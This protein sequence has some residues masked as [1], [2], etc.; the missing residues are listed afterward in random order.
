MTSSRRS[1]IVTAPRVFALVAGVLGLVLVLVTPP[2]AG[3]D[4]TAHFL[5]A[6]QVAELRLVP[7]RST[8]DA[9]FDTFPQG[10][11][12]DLQ[13]TGHD[14][15]APGGDRTAYRH[16]IR[17]A[18]PGGP[19]TRVRIGAIAGYDPVPY[20]PAAIAIRIGRWF[21]ASTLEL[22]YLARFAGLSVYVLLAAL[23]VARCRRAQWL[24]AVL[25]LLPVAMF[26]AATVTI[27]GITYALALL[28]VA[29]A[30]RGWLDHERWRRRDTVVAV[31][32]SLALGAAKPPYVLLALTLV[33]ALRWRA[34]LSRIAINGGAAA[35]LAV[36]LVWAKVMEGPLST[37]DVAFGAI[38]SDDPFHPYRHVDANKQLT[39]HI[40]RD[41]FGFLG[42][43]GRTVRDG[44]VDWLRDGVAQLKIANV[45]PN[46]VAILAGLAI[47]VACA[48]SSIGAPGRRSRLA[49]AV[50]ALGTAIATLV[51][52]YVSWNA[53]GSPDIRAYQGRYLA[54]VVPVVA[55]AVLRQRSPGRPGHPVRYGVAAFAI[56]AV[57]TCWYAVSVAGAF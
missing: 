35:A 17:D 46:A 32:A 24:I 54:P 48:G 28:V 22:L 36:S 8:A 19:P 21:G 31:A 50:V 39:Q 14:L 4:E 43:L 56:M 53:L 49:L 27:D 44:G 3:F 40:L 7:Q 6:Y 38:T 18:A 23:A 34:G 52:A 26:G 10:L 47:V 57:A 33:V 2:I 16:H 12:D 11:V 1:S 55:A 51:A 29:L 13:R 45:T 37:Q 42:V 30:L 41:P 25:A 20:I 15:L 5:R 9:G